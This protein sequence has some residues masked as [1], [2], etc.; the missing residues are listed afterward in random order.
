M[1]AT[2]AEART[3][4]D[5]VRP[6]LRLIGVAILV[7]LL[8]AAVLLYVFPGEAGEPTDAILEPLRF[9]WPVRPEL[10]AMFMGSC[11]GAGAYFS[12]LVRSELARGGRLLPGNRRLRLVDGHRDV[13]ALG[14]VQP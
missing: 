4:D 2:P 9:A 7:V 12:G 5:A 14:Q 11:Y 8:A 13:P 10:T 3:A 1:S 6:E